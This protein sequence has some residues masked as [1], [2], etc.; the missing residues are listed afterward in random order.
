VN[1]QPRVLGVLLLALFPSATA[2]HGEEH[3]GSG[4]D[5]PRLKME[6]LEV[7]GMRENP[8]VPDLPV[9]EGIYFLSPVRFDLIR[10]ELIRPVL[11]Q[12]VSGE[13]DPRPRA[14]P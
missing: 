14:R 12:A 9:P 8:D 4:T 3:R 2:G 7:R 1:F 13:T 10:E 5:L 6:E 11:P